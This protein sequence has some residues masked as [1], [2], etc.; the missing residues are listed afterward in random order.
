MSDA[1]TVP[2]WAMHATTTQAVIVYQRRPNRV[3]DW[4]AE[5]VATFEDDACSRVASPTFFSLWHC[6]CVQCV[7]AFLAVYAPGNALE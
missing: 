7:S 5:E 4:S 1:A 6:G 2:L 3:V